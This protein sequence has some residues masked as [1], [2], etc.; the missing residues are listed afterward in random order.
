MGNTLS[1]VERQGF[2][3]AVQNIM[4]GGIT[5]ATK[6]HQIL[7]DDHDADLSLSSVTRYVAK[8]KDIISDDAFKTIRDHV[9][10]V[11][12]EDLIALEEMEKQCLDWAKEDPSE[13]AD[14]LTEAA[15]LVDAEFDNWIVDLLKPAAGEKERRRQIKQIVRKAIGYVLK[16]ARLQGKRIQA[17]MTAIKIIDLKLRQAGLLDEEG[18]GRIIIIDRSGDYDENAAEDGSEPR[19]PYL[20]KT[21]NPNSTGAPHD[22]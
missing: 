17:M 16:D 12:P 10:K 8:I 9:D 5:T 18:K 14:R 22:P 13:L 6:I 15:L 7:Q 2:A 19:V 11:V 1:K 4:K 20:V 21:S 3:D